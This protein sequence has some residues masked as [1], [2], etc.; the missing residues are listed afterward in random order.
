MPASAETTLPGEPET[1][2]TPSSIG[3][4]RGLAPRADFRAALERRTRAFGRTGKTL[5]HMHPSRT[6]FANRCIAFSTFKEE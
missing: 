1:I 3:K 6:E 2:T 4:P 5:P